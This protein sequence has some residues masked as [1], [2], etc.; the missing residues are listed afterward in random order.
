MYPYFQFSGGMIPALLLLVALFFLFIFL[1]V[2]MVAEAFS[3]L[4]LTP[5]QGV[6]MFIAILVGRAINIPVFTS[7]RLVVVSKPRAVSFGLDEFGRPIQIEE[8][9]TNELKKQVFAINVGGF[10]LPLLLSLTFLI[11]QHMIGQ[12]DGVY[13]WIGFALI[14]V[15]LG[16]YITAKPDVLTGLRI[17]LVLPAIMT[18]LSVYFFVP[19]PFRPVAAYIAGTMGAIIGGNLIPLLIPRFRNSVGS[20]VVSIGGP[21]TFGGVFVAGILSVLLA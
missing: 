17:P 1:P 2:S 15:T 6:L 4:G 19:E 8:D 3:K 5:A 14:M 20:A 21:G 13:L 7:E 12:T 11:R 16:C 9:G 18:F 10:L